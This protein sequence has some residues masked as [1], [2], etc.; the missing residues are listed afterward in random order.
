MCVLIT[1]GEE[2]GGAPIKVHLE[3]VKVCLNERLLKGDFS[4]NYFGF[5]CEFFYLSV[6]VFGFLFLILNRSGLPE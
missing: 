6:K 3:Q 5:L 2:V 1:T 4:E